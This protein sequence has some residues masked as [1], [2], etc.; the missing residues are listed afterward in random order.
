MYQNKVTLIGFL[1]S[2]PEVRTAKNRSFT[3]FSLATKSSFKGKNSS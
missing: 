1:G 3:T 2:D